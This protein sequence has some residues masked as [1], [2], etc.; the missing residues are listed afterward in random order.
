MMK[1]LKISLYVLTVAGVIAFLY[2]ERQ[3]LSYLRHAEPSRLVFLLGA[4]I[5]SLLL[6]GLIFKKSALIFNLPLRARE[7]FGLSAVNTMYNYLLPARGGMAARALY[8]KKKYS[9]PYSDYISLS[10]G[11]YLLNLFAAAFLAALISLWF[12]FAGR[13]ESMA[14]LYISV[15]FLVSVSGGIVF[16]CLFNP[17]RIPGGNRFARFVRETARGLKKFRQNPGIARDMVL[18]DFLFILSLGLRLFIAYR[19]LGIPAGYAELVLISS[20]VAFSLVFSVTPGNIGIKEG[21]IG[22]SAG[23]LGITPEQAVL[24][25]VLDRV[26]NVISVFAAGL[27]FS[28]LMLKDIDPKRVEQPAQKSA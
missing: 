19:V 2:F 21:I 5:L 3:E 18:L 14:F 4:G 27:V 10:A 20:L 16:S 23:L 7:W 28:R 25:A 17:D 26:V 24:G 11:S 9:M 12:L 22:V 15:F 6:N 1:L 8:L 13:L